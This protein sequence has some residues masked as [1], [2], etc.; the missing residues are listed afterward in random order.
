[1]IDNG[2]R[3]RLHESERYGDPYGPAIPQGFWCLGMIRAARQIEIATRL[4]RDGVVS[5]AGLAE[6]L[7]VSAVT[8]RRDL[9]VM[10]K[11][12]LLV[13]THGG[14]TPMGSDYEPS[15]YRIR[16]EEHAKEKSA[17][18]RKASE[19]IKDGDSIILNA[20][21]TMH[22]LAKELRRFKQLSVVT[23]G[24][25]VA[26]ELALAEGIQ[27]TMI[28]GL[29]DPA[30][31][32][33]V[34]PMAEES[35]RDIRVSRAFLGVT[36]VSVD[37]GISMHSPI[38][39]QINKCFVRCAREVTVVIDSSKFEVP[40][41]HR[42]VPLTEVQRIITDEGLSAELRRKIEALGVELVIASEAKAD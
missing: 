26:A 7:G 17:V 41:L 4:R 39:A 13:R 20:G 38:E 14:A 27:V 32:G 34:G 22:E 6:Q 18:A 36:G 9:A 15:P 23:N 31:L 35:L 1:M 2:Q 19:Y 5:I 12:G 42:I 28:G 16:Q 11:A 37:H 24:L 30:K 3:G 29:V 33:S 21:T 25:T 8:I 40:S 10:E